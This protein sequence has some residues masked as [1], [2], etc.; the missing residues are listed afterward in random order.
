MGRR[1]KFDKFGAGRCCEVAT[2][3]GNSKIRLNT[4]AGLMTGQAHF[5]TA[6]PARVTLWAGVPWTLFVGSPG[7]EGL[8]LPETENLVK[9][10]MKKKMEKRWGWLI[11]M[12]VL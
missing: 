5:G 2:G 9:Q 10:G 3:M 1:D 8:F 4:E 7:C 6:F 11:C 12:Q